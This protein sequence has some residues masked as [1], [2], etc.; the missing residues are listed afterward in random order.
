MISKKI[1]RV[2]AILVCLG[3]I[4][5]TISGVAL[6]AEKKVQRPDVR[7]LLQKPIVLLNSL[8]N[9]FLSADQ[10]ASRDGEKAS[11]GATIK[12][13]GNLK[14]HKVSDGD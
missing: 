5:L 14:S 10:K 9:L 4:T 1:L 7:T 12:I 13:T 8:F 6:A 11:S 2:T 3:F